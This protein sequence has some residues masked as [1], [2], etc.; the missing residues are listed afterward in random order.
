MLMT[1]VYSEAIFFCV[2]EK[3]NKMMKKYIFIGLGGFLGAILRFL[4]KGLQ[5]NTAIPLN[6]LLIN[7]S[8]A[9]LLAFLLT[10]TPNFRKISD[11]LRLGI[12]AGFLGAFTTF[13][14]L[15]KEASGL[16]TCGD[17]RSAITYIVL[18]MILGLS[19]AYLGY[20]L[21]KGIIKS[22]R[23]LTSESEED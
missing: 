16:I 5:T 4:I 19:A 8:G 1:S 9:F 6:T 15:C 14:T 22:P 20:M 2:N 13:S 18:S 12:T 10:V 7:I 23:K 3:E 17:T 11:H 21:A